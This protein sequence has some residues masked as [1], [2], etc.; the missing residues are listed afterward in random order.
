MSHP[1]MQDIAREAGVGVA[2]VDRVINRRAS[3]KPAT[4][5]RVLNAAKKLGFVSDK[6]AAYPATVRL[7]RVGFILLDTGA[8]FYRQLSE[9]LRI[10]AGLATGLTLTTEFVWLNVNATQAIAEAILTLG[11]RAEAIGIVAI[12]NPLVNQAIDRVKE[13][14]VRVYTLFS[15]LTASGCAGY[16][17][18]DN[19]KAGRTAAW[20]I[21]RLSPRP[22]KIG[23]LLGDHRFLCQEIS[24]ISFRSWFREKA[25]GFDILEPLRSYED[26]AVAEQATRKLLQETPDLVALYVPSG[27][28]EGVVQA[29]LEAKRLHDRR[30][31][32]V[33]HGPIVSARRA[34]IEEV[35]DLFIWHP[36]AVLAEGILKAIVEDVQSEARGN[37]Q[38]YLSFELM[39]V[40]NF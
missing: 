15:E 2:T 39:T 17:G 16:I 37:Q 7:C 11:K 23:I 8:E 34:L 38:R 10:Q 22:G 24:E 28:V 1:T 18:L 31:T 19:R 25:A 30:L 36:M 3:V 14:G 40:E 21:A 5:L 27:G 12:D 9:Q 13:Q 29:L 33:C 32:V 26:D 6:L 20:M 4:E 35:V